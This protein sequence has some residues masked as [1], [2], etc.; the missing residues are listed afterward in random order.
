MISET[1][2]WL[3][4]TVGEGGYAPPAHAEPEFY[5][6]TDCPNGFRRRKIAASP[7]MR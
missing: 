3:P 1:G 7:E 6:L 4:R 5:F 2:Y